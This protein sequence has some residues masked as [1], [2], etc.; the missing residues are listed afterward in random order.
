MPKTDE[1]LSPRQTL[2]GCQICGLAVS[3]RGDISLA[4][5]GCRCVLKLDSE[6]RVLTVLKAESLGRRRAWF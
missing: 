2:N 4:A 6:G 5:T 1:C 3:S